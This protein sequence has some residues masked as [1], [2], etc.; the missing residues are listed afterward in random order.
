M[1]LIPRAGLNAS[2]TDGR[3]VVETGPVNSGFL[4]IYPAHAAAP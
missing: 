1:A 4:K 2:A 3:I